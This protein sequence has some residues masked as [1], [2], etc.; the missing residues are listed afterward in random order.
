MVTSRIVPALLGLVSLTALAAAGEV[1]VSVSQQPDL[2]AVFGQV[3]SDAAWA[4]MMRGWLA[5]QYVTA[6]NIGNVPT[7][8]APPEMA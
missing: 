4:Q 6:Q 3:E 7:V 8:Q 5:A 2:K 1:P